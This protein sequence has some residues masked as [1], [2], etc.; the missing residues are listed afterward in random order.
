MVC[1]GTT[2]IKVDGIMGVFASALRHAY[3]L[4]VGLIMRFYYQRHVRKKGRI[5][6]LLAA[7]AE[8]IHNAGMYSVDMRIRFTN[9]AIPSFSI[10]LQ[11]ILHLEASGYQRERPSSNRQYGSLTSRFPLGYLKVSAVSPSRAYP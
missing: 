9:E 4:N 3:S 5:F 1:K 10:L 6:D 11:C 7:S 8:Q 2:G